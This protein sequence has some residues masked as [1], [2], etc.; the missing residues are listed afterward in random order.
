MYLIIYIYNQLYRISVKE[1]ISENYTYITYLC[2][3]TEHTEQNIGQ[4]II[5]LEI[6]NKIQHYHQIIIIALTL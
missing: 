5:F 6:R 4:N 2:K 1:S 3:Y